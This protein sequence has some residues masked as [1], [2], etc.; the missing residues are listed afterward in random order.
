MVCLP[1]ADKKTR[2]TGT[3]LYA[4]TSSVQCS[5]NLGFTVNVVDLEEKEDFFAVSLMG[6]VLVHRVEKFC[7][8]NFVVPVFVENFEHPFDKES[9]KR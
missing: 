2:K 9:L 7:Q 6:R 3:H 5:L 1:R 4:G 8:R